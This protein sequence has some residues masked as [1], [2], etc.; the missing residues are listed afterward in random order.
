MNLIRFSRPGV[1][2]TKWLS[3]NHFTARLMFGYET[4]INSAI[5]WADIQFR[6]CFCRW[7]ST[8]TCAITGIGLPCISTG[9][10]CTRRSISSEG[11]NNWRPGTIVFTRA[12]T[13]RFMLYGFTSGNTTAA[14]ISNTLSTIAQC[15]FSCIGVASASLQTIRHT[16]APSN[17]HCS[18]W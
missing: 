14:C 1:N 4:P 18:N 7:Y 9:L 10:R 16:S 3:A 12:S 11:R 2:S 6:L 15:F 17:W 13:N 8:T 5:G